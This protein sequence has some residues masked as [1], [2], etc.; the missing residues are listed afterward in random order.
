MVI[1]AT[2]RLLFRDH[3][4]SDLEPFC[5]MEADPEVRRFVGGPRSRAGAERKFRSVYLPPVPDRLGLWATV[6]RPTAQYIGYCGVYPHF[7]PHSVIRGEGTL[8]F[9]LARAYWGLGLASEAGAAFVS[10]AFKDLGL[11]R[12]VATVQVGNNASV[13]VLEKLGFS[14][15]HLESGKS[16]SY[17]HYE[18][19]PS[20]DP[21]AA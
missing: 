9:Y 8:A 18:L 5:A 2:S 7:G 3:D 11:S 15:H 14:L 13:R 20:Q 19:R 21:S 4:I 10:F 16:R 12:L 6:F 17:T 1:L